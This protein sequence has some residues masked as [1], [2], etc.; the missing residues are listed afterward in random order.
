[1]KRFLIVLFALMIIAAQSFASS[2]ADKYVEEHNFCCHAAGA[3]KIT[4]EPEIDDNRYTYHAADGVDVIFTIKDNELTTFTC[5]CL[6]DEQIGEFLAQCVTAFYNMGGLMAYTYCHDPLL[7]DFLQARAGTDAE[8]DTTIP[9][10]IFGVQK[11]SFGY[12]F[13]LVKVK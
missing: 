13:I 5:V 9:G 1:M 3:T 10:L 12:V 2:P 11:K 7:T 6:K 8:K 4:G